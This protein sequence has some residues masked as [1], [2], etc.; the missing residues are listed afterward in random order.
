MTIMMKKTLT[1]ITVLALLIPN[2]FAKDKSEKEQERLKASGEVLQEVLDIPD[3][4]PVET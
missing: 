2:A 1:V 3:A 4:I